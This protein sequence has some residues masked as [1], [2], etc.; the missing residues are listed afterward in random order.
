[1]QKR[2]VYCLIPLLLI[3]TSLLKGQFRYSY[4]T[5]GKK[6]LWNENYMQAI[7]YFTYYIN[8]HPA[9]YEA[10]YLRGLAKYNLGDLSG[11]E[12]DFTKAIV[13]VPEFPRLYMVRGVVRS[14]NYKFQLALNDF[15]SAIELDS[16]YSDGYFYRSLNYISQLDYA[17]ALADVN[18]VIELDSS[19][20][21]I[22]LLRGAI[23]AQ[24][25]DYPAAIIDFNRCIAGNQH[26]D[27]AYIERGTAYAQLKIPDLAMQDF[28][29]ALAL[30]ST[31]A[32]AY[33][34]RALVKMRTMDHEGALEDLNRVLKLSPG[35]ELAL[36]NRA[37]IKSHRQAEGEAIAD[38]IHILNQNP[39][40]ML[41][42]YNMG[43]SL[44][45]IGN[46]KDAIRSFSSAI[47]LFPDYADA[48][49]QRALAYRE[50]GE[51]DAA[52]LDIQQYEKLKKK[53]YEKDDS[54]KY[55]EGQEIL[56][57]THL[58]DEFINEEEKKHK[59]QY[60]DI[61]IILQ[62]IF[63]PVLDSMFIQNIL[64]KTSKYE[65][66]CQMLYSEKKHKDSVLVET[67]ILLL[68]SLLKKDE[69]NEDLYFKRGIL[70]TAVN[71]PLMAVE[72]FSKALALNPENPLIQFN[73][74]IANITLLHKMAYQ[75]VWI[76]IL[77]KT[78]NIEELRIFSDIIYDLQ[79]VLESVPDYIYALYNMGYARFLM[80]DFAG[81]LAD[82]TIVANRRKI[83]E[84]HFNKALLQI[85]LDKKE[86]GCFD[87]GIA[88]ELGLKDA[89]PVIRIFCK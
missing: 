19:Y 35:N 79:K 64:S 70:Y 75:N 42:F 59:I 87:L 80:E 66:R 52:K 89:Y 14:E 11:A 50:L 62:P 20:T 84:A 45:R 85:L 72:D 6:E 55:T 40:N 56:R 54:T 77:P 30:D 26:M 17:S 47:E 21:D 81:A 58:S 49:Y 67:H 78:R 57:L 29:S 22:Y 38:F 18:K 65:L 68:D 3:T 8:D 86:E 7:N 76:P 4:I 41:V 2:I 88:G 5:L 44:A 36:F 9:L 60:N 12:Y 48:Y 46:F 74:A 73:R 13:C 63:Q 83:A 51:M 16:T 34:Q 82:F 39:D 61:E 33:F 71:E 32:Y 27:R 37:L 31:N 1:M 10:Y 24:L 53:N 69:Y 23:Y 25:Q 15:N 43:I 28:E